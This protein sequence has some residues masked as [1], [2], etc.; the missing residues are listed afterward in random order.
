MTVFQSASSL[1][2]LTTGGALHHLPDQRHLLGPS[3][4]STSP[5]SGRPEVDETAPRGAQVHG[6]LAGS[7]SQVCSPDPAVLLWVL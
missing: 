6:G 5:T 7:A 4:P 3:N 1:T 2:V